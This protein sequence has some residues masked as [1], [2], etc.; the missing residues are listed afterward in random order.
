[1]ELRDYARVLR[2]R[3][4]LVGV[5]LLAGL[6]AAVAAIALTTRTYNAHAQLFVATSDVSSANAYQ[7]GLFSQERVKSY[8]QIVNSPP[9][10][11]RVVT[12][13]GLH[14]SPERL[15]KQISATAPLDT[16]LIDIKVTDASPTRAQAIANATAEQFTQ[17]VAQIEQSS[18]NGS[19]LVKVSVVG[20]SAAP[21]SPA[22]PQPVLY[23]G[24]GVLAGLGVGVSGALL[25]SA[26]DTRMKSR[27]DV[28]TGLGLTTVGSVPADPALRRVR[29]LPEAEGSQRAEALSQLCT[30]IRYLGGDHRPRSVVVTS[31][32]PDEGRTATAVDLAVSL[33]RTGR[34]VVLVEGDLR[35]PRLAE[36]L[37]LP[38]A[39]GLG[40]LLAGRAGLSAALQDWG[41]GLLRVVTAGEPAGEPAQ[42]L[43]SPALGGLL[44]RLEEQA[45]LVVLDSPPL[46]PFA[47]GAVL[48]AEAGDALL[49]VRSGRTKRAP[50]R[51]ALDSLAAV[52][53]HVLGVVLTMTPT[54]AGPSQRT[55]PRAQSATPW[56][57]PPHTSV[58]VN[59]SPQ[60][61]PERRT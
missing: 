37:G 41:G 57:E 59:G 49:V 55:S 45:D 18:P 26:L 40:Q 24:I 29:Q 14:T 19:A 10:V 44:R 5:C 47:D 8:T 4:R 35:R 3:W 23:L 28:R 46:L 7:G 30:N 38:G 48:A 36:Y 1:M 54:R 15:A 33:A 52:D 31:A 2:E 32:L 25:R 9:V 60:P 51:R 50:A 11:D 6:L 20:P 13:L 56:H 16:V 58:L 39:V 17:F 22:S 21:T 42:L 12:A 61:A 27:E 43:A 53:A 34:R